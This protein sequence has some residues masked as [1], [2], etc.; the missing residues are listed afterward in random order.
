MTELT[1]DPFETRLT[2]ALREYVAGAHD[3]RPAAQI[4]DVAMRPRGVARR[5]GGTRSRRLLLLGVAAV[6]LVPTAY[7]GARLLLPPSPVVENHVPAGNWR[8]IVVRRTYADPG[9]AIFAVGADGSEKLL[10]HV[11]DS[12]LPSGQTFS[13]FG[14]V[15]ETGWIA[16]GESN[17]PWNM[18]LVDL[19]DPSSQPWIV[20]GTSVGGVSPE[21]GP[22]GLVAAQADNAVV[23]NG[24]VMIVNPDTRQ[25][26]VTGTGG[27]GPRFVFPANTSGASL[28][29]CTV[30]GDCPVADGSVELVDVSGAATKIFEQTGADRASGATFGI[31]PDEYLIQLDGDAG[32]QIRIDRVAGST[33]EQILTLDR[34]VAWQFYWFSGLAPDGSFGTLSVDLGNDTHGI[35]IVPTGNGPATYHHASLAGYLGAAIVDAIGPTGYDISLAE[36]IGAAATAPYPISPI[37]DLIAAETK[38]NPGHT[39]VG[40]GSRDAV[41][42]DPVVEQYA[43]TALAT[44]N[45]DVYL[46]CFGAAPVT[47]SHNPDSITSPCTLLGGYIAS[48]ANVQSG[49]VVTVSASHD[50]SW[51]LTLYTFD[52]AQFD[53]TPPP[54]PAPADTPTP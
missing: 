50:T 2:A 34:P 9:V 14:S 7:F 53:G 17:R 49:D 47:V 29:V 41:E 30:G 51:R 44:G 5:L 20:H 37:E 18:V 52:Q 3:P 15:S 26:S 22:Q 32:R 39:P 6:L 27:A 46:S 48:F 35:A 24:D 38:L 1:R 12:A 19:R 28:R 45:L 23:T 11:S 36:P 31:Q 43:V 8:A 54:Q 10:R 42:G 13:E 4:A 40:Q 16:L 21:W 33:I 25:T